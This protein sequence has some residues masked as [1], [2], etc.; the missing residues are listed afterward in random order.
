MPL[1][2]HKSTR[3]ARKPSAIAQPAA[4]DASLLRKVDSHLNKLEA[5]DIVRLLGEEIDP[6]YI[7]K[8][9]LVQETTYDT[10]LKTKRAELHRQ[11]AETIEKLGPDLLEQNAAVLAFHYQR[12]GWD[13]MAF[14]YAALAGDVAWRAYAHS[15]A[16]T[17]YDLALGISGRLDTSLFNPRIR[18]VFTKRGRIYEVMGD[19]A[20]A[21]ENYRAMIAFAERA[22]DPLMEAE[23]LNHLVTVQSLA[24]D[25]AISAADRHLDRALELARRADDKALIGRT[26]WNM[27]LIRRFSDPVRATEYFQQALDLARAANLRE[28]AGYAL[29]E[30]TIQMEIVGRPRAAFEFADQALVEFRALE[31]QPM[32]VDALGGRSVC[33]FYLGEVDTSRQSAEEGIRLSRAT[34]NIWG[35][36]YNQLALF[37]SIRDA[38]EFDRLL[39]E[40]EVLLDE[41]RKLGFPPFRCFILNTLIRAY[42]ELDQLDRVQALGDECIQAVSQM[43]V[44]VWR[45]VASAAQG[46]ALLHRGKLEEARAVLDPLWQ[47][48]NQHIETIF[49]LQ[50]AGATIPELALA[51]GQLDFGL[52]FCN[53][54]LEQLE[55]E[56]TWRLACD[57]YFARARLC[58]ARSDMQSAEHDLNRALEIAGQ[59]RYLL[60]SWRLHAELGRLY[61]QRD[62]QPRSE[63][64]F[65]RG[66]EVIHL[67]A[68]KIPDAKLRASFLER[69]EVIQL[70]ADQE[71]GA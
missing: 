12:G 23:G 52:A 48:G 42:I 7:F 34:E 21:T 50:F 16:L 65:R 11:V 60:L 67:L 38:G 19:P 63:A 57:I 3:K 30:L 71:K 28:L 17:H 61:A 51:R 49:S 55:R 40:G 25:S 64:A 31:N 69:K 1:S 47:I 9:Q 59:T 58:K 44:Q 27:G 41:T 54:I 5:A 43:D 56:K 8:H 22:K 24:G 53:W 15:E 18:E 35:R 6:T 2:T 68:G 29:V 26:L 10:M 14:V 62:D 37:Q 36:V 4:P 66:A 13:D 33:A 45:D 20:A 46:T 32:V 39:T 70:L